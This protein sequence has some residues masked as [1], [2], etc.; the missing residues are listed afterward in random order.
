MDTITKQTGTI[1]GLD[2]QLDDGSRRFNLLKQELAEEN[3]TNSLLTQKIEF[4]ELEKENSINYACATKSTYCEASTLKENVEL[5]A[6]LE[7]LT[8]K[9]RKLEESHEKLLGSH[10][11]LIISHDGLKLYREASTTKITSCEP[12]LD[13]STI[14]TQNA[15]FPCASPSDPSSH[16][17]D[18]PCV[19]LL[20]LPCCS[21]NEAST[22]SSTSS[23]T[24]HVEEI[25]ELKAQVTSLKKDFEKSHEG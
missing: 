19:G 12:T 21:N 1:E 22:S 11:D 8:S 4:Y 5:R 2:F 10:N 20:D 3:H 7:L 23:S 24:N 25:K 6:Q 16:T 13:I 9:Y 18:K 15:I 17:S 14:S